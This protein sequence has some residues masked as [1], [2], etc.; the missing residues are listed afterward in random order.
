MIDRLSK[1]TSIFTLSRESL[2]VNHV[3]FASSVQV[4]TASAVKKA[5]KDIISS[6]TFDIDDLAYLFI[7]LEPIVASNRTSAAAVRHELGITDSAEVECSSTIVTASLLFHDCDFP[8]SSISFGPKDHFST[9]ITGE[10][11]RRL[12]L[13][14]YEIDLGSFNELLHYPDIM[15]Y[16]ETYHQYERQIINKVKSFVT[17][18]ATKV[19]SYTCWNR[20]PVVAFQGMCRASMLFKILGY[21]SP[22]HARSAILSRL[23]HQMSTFA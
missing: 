12:K 19:L 3:S 7:D 16:E 15:R 18:S 11:K 6:K 13:R 20:S 9:Y 14:S 21:Y 17:R 8:T 10:I 5:W 4:V 2:G 1:E 22:N 23:P